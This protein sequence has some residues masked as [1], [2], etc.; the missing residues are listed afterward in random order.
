MSRDVYLLERTLVRGGLQATTHGYLVSALRHCEPL[1]HFTLLVEEHAHSPRTSSYLFSEVVSDAEEANQRTQLFR[2]ERAPCGPC[3][4]TR[5]HACGV[6]WRNDR[7]R[8]FGCT[9]AGAGSLGPA[10]RHG[11]REAKCISRL[12]AP[13]AFSNV[14]LRVSHGVI[15]LSI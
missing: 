7:H 5:Q 6:V 3:A 1:T 14:R 4:L 10:C 15:C 8:F 9:D 11:P 13:F 2:A 12:N